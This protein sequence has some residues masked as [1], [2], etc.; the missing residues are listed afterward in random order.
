MKTFLISLI[1]AGSWAIAQEPRPA[2]PLSPASP[3]AQ[4]DAAAE[5]PAVEPFVEITPQLQE[6]VDRGLSYLSA[7]QHKDGSFGAGPHYSHHVAITSLAAMAFMS[8]GSVPGRGRYGLQV[9]LAL[10]FVLSNCTASGLIAARVGHGPMYGHAFSTLFLAEAYGMS[11]HDQ[12]KEKL[13][14][15]VRLIEDAQ[16][17]EGG[18]RYQPVP[19]DADLSVTV[20]QIMALRAARN[21]GIKVRKGTIDAGIEYIRNAQNPDGGFRYMLNS[22]A[23]GFDRSAGALAAL[24]Y[25]GLSSGSEFDAGLEYM[26]RYLPGKGVTGT[27]YFYGQYYAV[28]TMFLAGGSYWQTWFPAIR[29]ELLSKQAEN[30]SWQGQAG[31]AYGTAMALIVLQVPNRLLPIF[32]R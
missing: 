27:H 12:L 19:A 10:D 4:P 25:S 30:G 23:S 16:N 22:G 32:Q 8:E 20:C 9:E 31:T 18:W 7:Q 5:T 15:A 26:M 24:Y 17:H 29:E 13:R 6:A 3:E 14:K 1:V 21:V 2:Q 11:S 28:Q